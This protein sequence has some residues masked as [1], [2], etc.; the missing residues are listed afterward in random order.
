MKLKTYVFVVRAFNECLYQLHITSMLTE[1]LYHFISH[2][3]NSTTESEAQDLKLLCNLVK[4]YT[5]AF[6]DI[7]EAMVLFRRSFPKLY[8]ANIEVHRHH[9]LKM[10]TSLK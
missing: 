3:R 1:S 8:D 2:M 5:Q 10:E 7:R 4:P 6:K 9:Y